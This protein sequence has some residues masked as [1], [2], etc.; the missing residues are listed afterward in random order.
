MIDIKVESSKTDEEAVHVD[1]TLSDYD[2]TSAKLQMD[3][4]SLRD[5]PNYGDMDSIVISFND[6]TGVL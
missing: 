4:E 1:W 2:R 3:L 5:S 6:A